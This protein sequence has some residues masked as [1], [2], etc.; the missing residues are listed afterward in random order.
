MLKSLSEID[1]RK[2]DSIKARRK[3]LNDYWK[4]NGWDY[5]KY[6]ERI[7]TVFSDKFLEENIK[8]DYS[9]WDVVAQDFVKDMDVI[10]ELVAKGGRTTIDNY[11]KQKFGV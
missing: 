3:V 10:I 5:D 6:P 11:V 2:T 9:K 8:K 4:D 7:V 1:F